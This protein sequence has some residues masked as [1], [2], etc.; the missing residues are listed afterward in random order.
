MIVAA[1]PLGS[2]EWR[3]ESEGR[4][5]A[6]VGDTWTLPSGAMAIALDGCTVDGRTLTFTAPGSA[7][8]EVAGQ[9]Y[10]A[11]VWSSTALAWLSRLVATSRD[12]GTPH[13]I[14]TAL[15]RDESF[16][17]AAARSRAVTDQHEPHGGLAG[18]SLGRFGLGRPRIDVNTERPMV[19]GG[20][21]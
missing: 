8:I 6:I 18:V 9:R 4:R 21:R 19:E 7:R 16:T 13:G 1:H 2:V 3:P 14:L 5:A 15:S 11:H 12:S 10:E 20:S 17:A